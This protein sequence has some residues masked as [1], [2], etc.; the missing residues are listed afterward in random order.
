MVTTFISLLTM[1][2]SF[3][4]T[5]FQ[6]GIAVFV[7]IIPENKNCLHE[8]ISAKNESVGSYLFGYNHHLIFFS[9]LQFTSMEKFWR[10]AMT[11]N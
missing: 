9:F 4:R 5:A 7:E 3:N 11:C 10:F 8:T 1:G 2:D 6:G